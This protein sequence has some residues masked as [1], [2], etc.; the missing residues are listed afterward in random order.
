MVIESATGFFH[1]GKDLDRD[2]YRGAYHNDRDRYR[3]AYPNDKDGYQGAYKLEDLSR[4]PTLQNIQTFQTTYEQPLN[5]GALYQNGRLILQ[6][7]AS[8]DPKDPMNLPMARKL[9]GIFCL[10]FFGALAASAEII[11]GA[12]LPVF[13]IDYARKDGVFAYQTVDLLWV[14]SVNHRERADPPD[15]TIG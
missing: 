7:A 8:R 13:A 6:P 12:L 15:S 9:A 11:L 4:E 5:D 2:G 14:S 1:A 10:S 3:G